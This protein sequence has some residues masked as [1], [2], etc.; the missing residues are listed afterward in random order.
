MMAVLHPRGILMKA[1]LI[2]GCATLASFGLA[3]DQAEAGRS[4]RGGSYHVD[5][6]VGGG[7]G[8]YH[9]SPPVICHPP[10][11]VYRPPVYYSPPAYC[12]PPVYYA[13]PVYRQ[14]VYRAPVYRPPVYHGGYHRGHRG[15]HCW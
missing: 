7:Y 2:A 11:P 12:P 8:G 14:P 15:N 3:P 5:V 1:W 9:H 13:P 6:R 10:R 4:H